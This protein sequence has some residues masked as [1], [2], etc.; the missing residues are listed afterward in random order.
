MEDSLKILNQ[1]K[2]TLILDYDGN[3]SGKFTSEL[4]Q[5]SNL[6]DLQLFKKLAEDKSPILSILRSDLSQYALLLS[7]QIKNE[8][9][10]QILATKRDDNIFYQALVIAG[11]NMEIAREFLKFLK[12]PASK[13]ILLDSG[14][15]V[16]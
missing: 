9:D 1:N 15:I 12:N 10:F 7:S 5:N 11:D 2:S 6:L 13:K 16:D 8:H 4:V 3:S 14:F